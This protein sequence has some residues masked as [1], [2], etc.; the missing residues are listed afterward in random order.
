MSV[1]VR[2]NG[3]RFYFRLSVYS[4]TVSKNLKTLSEIRRI[5]QFTK[6]KYRWE[7]GVETYGGVTLASGQNQTSDNMDGHLFILQ[8]KLIFLDSFAH[9]IQP[10]LLGKLYRQMR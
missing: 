8:G 7:F 9:F 3:K 6:K 10:K 5:I 4:R 1:F 2:K